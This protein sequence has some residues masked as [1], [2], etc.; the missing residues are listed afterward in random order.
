MID[1]NSMNPLGNL[2]GL[3]HLADGEPAA[4]APAQQAAPQPVVLRPSLAPWLRLDP[5][6]LADVSWGVGPPGIGRVQ[7]VLRG[8]DGPVMR[9]C[10]VARTVD[11]GVI[12]GHLDQR[13]GRFFAIDEGGG[14]AAVFYPAE[15]VPGGPVWR[16]KPFGA[17]ASLDALGAERTRF[18][19]SLLEAS[20]ADR[21]LADLRD[22]VLEAAAEKA[23]PDP[24]VT[25]ADLDEAW[26]LLTEFW[27]PRVEH[28]LDAAIGRLSAYQRQHGRVV[29]SLGLAYLRAGFGNELTHE[30]E[31]RDRLALTNSCR[32]WSTLRAELGA[33]CQTRLSRIRDRRAALGRELQRLEARSAALKQALQAHFPEAQGETWQ[34]LFAGLEKRWCQEH[35]LLSQGFVPT[36][37]IGQG[38]LHRNLIQLGNRH[39]APQGSAELAES[40]LGRLNERTVRELLIGLRDLHLSSLNNLDLTRTSGRHELLIR[41]LVNRTRHTAVE[42]EELIA[43]ETIRSQMEVMFD[44]LPDGVTEEEM[45]AVQTAIIAKWV[46]EATHNHWWNCQPSICPGSGLNELLDDWAHLQHELDGDAIDHFEEVVSRPE[47]ARMIETIRH[48]V[49][50]FRS[51][52]IERPLIDEEYSAIAQAMQADRPDVADPSLSGAGGKFML[53]VLRGSRDALPEFS[54]REWLANEQSL[55]QDYLKRIEESTDVAASAAGWRDEIEEQF[56]AASRRDDT[57]RMLGALAQASALTRA[58]FDHLGEGATLGNS[59]GVALSMMNRRQGGGVE[60]GH[61]LTR[62]HD[63]WKQTDLANA[64]RAATDTGAWFISEMEPRAIDVFPDFPLQQV[65]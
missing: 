37:G 24:S 56:G 8:D 19:A 53:S 41:H 18:Q 40:V 30:I 20:W 52:A 39:M 38:G 46:A 35:L 16:Q 27:D 58:L 25:R 10:D 12:V 47:N 26:A 55:S 3:P 63:E 44:D 5:S 61:A 49:Y 28:G 65:G 29:L 50:V 43:R 21:E 62:W 59:V 6:G 60:I 23:T 48:A 2:P 17:G 57:R 34:G 4:V 64:R 13:S 42:R 15:Q 22:R 1:P 36:P 31:L 33:L 32:G 11:G 51:L 54:A 14:G 45:V 7:L 9:S